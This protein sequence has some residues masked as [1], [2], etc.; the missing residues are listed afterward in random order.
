M[1]NSLS[2]INATRGERNHANHPPITPFDR[3][4]DADGVEE[5]LRIT[6]AE[7]KSQSETG[8]LVS[9]IHRP[10]FV[11]TWRHQQRG[12]RA[13]SAAPGCSGFVIFYHTINYSV[14]LLYI[15]NGRS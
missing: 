10:H 11:S 12:V 5:A 14:W 1:A 7:G 13:S 8:L 9:R 15:A 3:G 6:R 4:A 2:S